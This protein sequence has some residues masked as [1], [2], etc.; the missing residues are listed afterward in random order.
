MQYKRILFAVF[1][2]CF[3]TGCGEKEGDAVEK[4]SSAILTENAE[5][6]AENENSSVSY[7]VGDVVTFGS[8][9]QDD[10]EDNGAEPI[11]WIVLDTDGSK[12]LLLSKYVLDEEQYDYSGNHVTWYTSNIFQWLNAD[13]KNEAFSDD[14]KKQIVNSEYGDVFLLSFD[15]AVK[16]FDMSPIQ[17]HDTIADMDY[18][19]YYSEKALAEPTQYASSG[20]TGAKELKQE[21]YDGLTDKGVTYSADIVGNIYAP[22]WLRT[23][24][25]GDLSCVNVV[26]EQGGL[27]DKNISNSAYLLAKADIGVR[28]AI[29]IGEDNSDSSSN[30]TTEITDNSLDTDNKATDV[31]RFYGYNLPLI[32]S[33]DYEYSDDDTLV[34]NIEDKGEYYL[35]SG[36]IVC[37]ECVVQDD[38]YNSAFE[39]GSGHKYT[40]KSTE[41]YNNDQREKIVLSGEDGQ[42][43]SIF[44]VPAFMIDTYTKEEYYPISNENNEYFK[45]IFEN[46][47]LQIAKDTVFF[48]GN[49]AGDTFETAVNNGT[50]ENATYS[51]AYD[52]HFAED[53]SIDILT[54]SDIGSNGVMGWYDSTAVVWREELNR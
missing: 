48:D 10:N 43:Y 46:V 51:I 9:E 36:S 52:I 33:L 7:A 47:V 38:V 40:Y 22:Y 15:E 11:E 4:N 13:F 26:N 16:Y 8:Y 12:T 24:V 53:G 31:S 23:Q 21:H 54:P 45:T 25:E 27:R 20:Y 49:S 2:V 3:L 37:P 6:Q 17:E 30:L 5:V 28:P 44:N 18:T 1:A 19:C 34:Y 14:E 42:E 41:A 50:F 39:T 29:W 35:V 32:F